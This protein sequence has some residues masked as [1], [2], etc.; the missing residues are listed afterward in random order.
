[1]KMSRRS[2]IQYAG[3]LPLVPFSTLAD[4]QGAGGAQ[5]LGSANAIP[6]LPDKQSFAHMS[7]T[8]LDSGG[9][10]PI[11]LGAKQALHEWI[12]ARTLEVG[13]PPYAKETNSIAR[14]RLR[15]RFA[16]LINAKPEEICITQ[17]TT[18]GENLVVQALGIPAS[19]GRIVTDTL[20]YP[21][22]VYLYQSLQKAG[23]DVT[24]VRPR[25]GRSID[26]DDLDHAI[27]KGTR[28]VAITLVSN[29]NGFQHDLAKVCE[30][31]HAKGAYVYADIAQAA[32]AVPVDVRAANVDFASCAGYKWLMGDFGLGLLY[33]RQDLLPRLRRPLFGYLQ[34]AKAETHVYPLDTPGDSVADFKLRDDATGHFATGTTSALVTTQL[35]YSLD[36]IRRIGVENIQRYRQPLLDHAR[37]ELE[38]RGYPCMTPAGATSPNLSFVYKDAARLQERLSA[39]RIKLTL[40]D[41][42]F[43]V[44]PS[45]FNDANDID[46]LVEVLS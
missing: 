10:H 12:A 39:A 3:A 26:L 18:A 27:R 1:M 8:W 32:G 22:S 2:W 20:H 35:N 5:A 4:A 15:A 43:R 38:K 13:A 31:A 9:T 14:D 44:S 41:N 37:V 21:N 36:Y 33:V 25:D 16:S 19:R 30:I 7:M 11:S 17:S 34:V 29:V 40:D 6:V 46:K 23:M 24:W 42:H 45:V 28:L